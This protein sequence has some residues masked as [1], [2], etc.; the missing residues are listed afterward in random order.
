MKEESLDDNEA[1]ESFL[2][3][4]LSG[5]IIVFIQKELLVPDFLEARLRRISNGGL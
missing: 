4:K 3:Q 5:L 2:N 1:Q